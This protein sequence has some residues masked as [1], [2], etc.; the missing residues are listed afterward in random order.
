V[1]HDPGPLK[2][3][4]VTGDSGLAHAEDFLEFGDGELGFVEEE[5]KPEAG[6]IGQEPEQ[7]N[8]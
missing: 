5:E 8:G 1:F 2:L 6:G 4:E 7:I 3:G